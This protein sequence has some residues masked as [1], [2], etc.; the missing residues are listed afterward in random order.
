[1]EHKKHNVIVCENQIQVN[2]IQLAYKKQSKI[3]I[4]KIPKILTLDNWIASEYQEFLMIEKLQEFYILNGIEEKIIWEK[5]IT[6]DL[7]K[8]QEKKITD[9]TNIAQ[10]AINA[11]RIISNHLIH[12][13]ELHQSNSYRELS[14]FL[15]W[16][17]EFKE[18]CSKKKLV[19]K[20]DFINIF[21]TLQQEKFIVVGKDILFIGLDKSIASLKKLYDVLKKNNVVSEDL[22]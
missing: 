17:K 6:N 1:M 16:R 14:Y 22:C 8:R 5:I 12:D 19:T 7:K 9:V 13:D 20:Y 4:L 15:E 2:N 10:K 3:N 11:N 21:I 18:E